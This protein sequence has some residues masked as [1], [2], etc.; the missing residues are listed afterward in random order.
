[1]R[2]PAPSPRAWSPERT[3]R[4][5]ERAVARSYG[6]ALSG[7]AARE[8]GIRLY[9]LGNLPCSKGQRTAFAL[10]CALRRCLS[11]LKV[12]Q[13]SARV[14][15]ANRTWSPLPSGVT[16]QMSVHGSSVC[17]ASRANFISLPTW[18]RQR[19]GHAHALP[20]GSDPKP[21]QQCVVSTWASAHPPDTS[22]HYSDLF[23]RPQHRCTE[24]D[25]CFASA[26]VISCLRQSAS[27][28]RVR[29]FRISAK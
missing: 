10:M 6:Q 8:T 5:S 22:R 2:A 16:P 20:T 15:C 29:T 25:R 1:M 7:P 9:M 28:R 4:F 27:Q 19:L 12:Q 21:Q 24:R 11:E 18:A 23:S 14:H 26:R 17:H 13:I 3:S